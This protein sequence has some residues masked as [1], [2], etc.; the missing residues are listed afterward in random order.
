M[1]SANKDT[2]SKSPAFQHA[3]LFVR[4]Q[5]NAAARAR[6]DVI[7]CLNQAGTEFCEATDVAGQKF[8]LGIAIG[9]DG[10]MLHAAVPP[11]QWIYR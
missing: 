3:I 5:S 8:D 10:S 11:W 6:T 4:P 7:S 1:A 9:G 2:S